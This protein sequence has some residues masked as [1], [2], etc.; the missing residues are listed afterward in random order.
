MKEIRDKEN[1]KKRKEIRFFFFLFY[2]DV[3]V[4]SLSCVSL[5]IGT[6]GRSKE[7]LVG[8][9][10]ILGGDRTESPI[11]SEAEKGEREREY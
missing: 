10:E 3:F 11:D 4:F 1:C 9:W 5:L 8:R 7:I 2:F 6:I